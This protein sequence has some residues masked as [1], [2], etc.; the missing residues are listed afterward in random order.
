MKAIFVVVPE[1][2]ELTCSDLVCLYLFTIYIDSTYS[3]EQPT[4]SNQFHNYVYITVNFYSI[5]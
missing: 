4:R 3:T 1:P 5:R 2:S